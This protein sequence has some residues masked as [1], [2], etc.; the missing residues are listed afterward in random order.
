ML[1]SGKAKAEKQ[2]EIFSKVQ[3]KKY[4]FILTIFNV[5]I[6]MGEKVT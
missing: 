3:T 5:K 1:P 2:S 4:L 6:K